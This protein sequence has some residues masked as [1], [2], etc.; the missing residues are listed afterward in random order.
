MK[1]FVQAKDES[2]VINGEIIVT[3]L[4]ILDDNVILAVDASR[5]YLIFFS[6]LWEMRIILLT[7]VADSSRNCPDSSARST[8]GTSKIMLKPIHVFLISK[9]ILCGIVSAVKLHVQPRKPIHDS[10]LALQ[11]QPTNELAQESLFEAF[12][13]KVGLLQETVSLMNEMRKG[14]QA[15][16]AKIIGN[17]NKS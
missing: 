4:D 16:A 6:G 11:T 9:H 14:N 8:I 17:M 1:V 13:R 15:E 2:I 5:R 12:R 10:R 7:S 3:V